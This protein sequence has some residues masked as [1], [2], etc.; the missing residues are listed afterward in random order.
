VSGTTYLAVK[1]ALGMLFAAAGVTKLANRS[2]FTKS[3]ERYELLPSFTVKPTAWAIPILESLAAAGLLLG[4]DRFLTA[5]AVLSLALL[6]TFT[7][8]V[9]VNLSRGRRNVTC[10]CFGPTARSI[11]WWLPLRNLAL[12]AGVLAVAVQPEGRPASTVGA[13]ALAAYGTALLLLV[14]A[15]ETMRRLRSTAP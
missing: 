9:V 15:Y 5:S 1:L 3:L 8:A 2:E 13:A 6:S 10:A 12:G 4:G 7:A 14:S 11:S